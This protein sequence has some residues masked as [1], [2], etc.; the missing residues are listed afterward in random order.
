MSQG[1]PSKAESSGNE[2]FPPSDNQ[3]DERQEAVL[4]SGAGSLKEKRGK[5]AQA[6]YG[7]L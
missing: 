1:S 4:G 2:M 3:G 6:S 5:I 7:W